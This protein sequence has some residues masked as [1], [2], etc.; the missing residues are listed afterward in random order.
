V[1]ALAELLATKS[2]SPLADLVSHSATHVLVWPRVSARELVE[3]ELDERRPTKLSG[4]QSVGL[5]DTVIWHTI[6]ED[7]DLD[8]PGSI[9]ILVTNDTGFLNSDKSMLH[10]HLIN[11][12]E[13]RQIDPDRVVV[14]RDLAGATLEAQKFARRISKR[15]AIVRK[16]FL[17]YM[18]SLDRLDWFGHF[19]ARE[20][21]WSNAETFP[22]E[23]PSYLEQGQVVAVDVEGVE[24][25]SNSDPAK[26]IGHAVLSFDGSMPTHEYFSGDHDD[27]EWYDGDVEDHYLTVSISRRVRVEATVEVD[28]AKQEALVVEAS[29][30]WAEPS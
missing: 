3:R 6:L 18:R 11:D 14:Q 4:D 24:S 8:D 9:A 7:I 12:L 19:D 13:S 20:G 15:D 2:Q 30:E 23:A 21:D 29:F 10:D 5:R 27:V 25:V 16:E 17:N 1:D 22:A 26:C 28:M